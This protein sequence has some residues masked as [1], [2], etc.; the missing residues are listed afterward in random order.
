VVNAVAR[1]HAMLVSLVIGYLLAATA[2]FWWWGL[3]PLWHLRL[4]YSWFGAAWGLASAL[5]VGAAVLR[6]QR[7]DVLSAR[8]LAGAFVVFLLIP[9][10]QSTFQSLKQALPHIAPFTWDQRLMVADRA[11]HL[12][13]QPWEYLAWLFDQPEWLQLLDLLYFVWFL[14]LFVFL[15]WASWTS[16][17]TLRVQA[18]ASVLLVWIVVGTVAAYAFSSAGPCYYEFVSSGPNPYVPLMERLHQTHDRTRVLTAVLNQRGVWRASREGR[19]VTFG[20]VSAMPS[21]HVALAVLLALVGWQIS[22]VV[23]ALATLYAIAIQV[24]SVILGWHYG[25]DGYAGGAMAWIIWRAAARLV[26]S[27]L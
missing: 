7:A 10:F 16:R 17:R 9:P 2:W 19:W 8:R 11:V 22:P 6:G 20:G 15:V 4:W 14:M 18:L 26:P 24:G 5:W 12:G 27:R 13:R 23:G 3:L 21:V 1:E 25:I